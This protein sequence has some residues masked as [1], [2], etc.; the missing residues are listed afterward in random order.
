MSVATDPVNSRRLALALNRA[1]LT[2][3][4][5]LDAADAALRAGTWGD[6]PQWLR[7]IVTETERE[8]GPS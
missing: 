3:S 6:L 1:D 8:H 5:R 7:N 2:P 4:E